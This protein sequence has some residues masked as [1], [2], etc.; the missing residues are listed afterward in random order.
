MFIKGSSKVKKVALDAAFSVLKSGNQ[1]LNLKMYIKGFIK[2]D[3]VVEIEMLSY[4]NEFVGVTKD[5]FKILKDTQKKDKVEKKSVKVNSGVLDD[6]DD[7]SDE[8]SNESSEKEVEDDDEQE[9][10]VYTRED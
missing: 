4:D 1:N 8:N 6:D 3:L 10:I 5:I 2:E 7:F 9:Y